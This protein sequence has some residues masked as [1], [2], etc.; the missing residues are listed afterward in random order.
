MLRYMLELSHT[1]VVE[2]FYYL[3]ENEHNGHLYG[4]A[5]ER[6]TNKLIEWF[7]K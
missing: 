7:L 5:F 6:T 2:A 1:Q 3:G 4:R